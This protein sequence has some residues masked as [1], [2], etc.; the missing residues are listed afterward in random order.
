MRVSDVSINSAGLHFLLAVNTVAM[1]RKATNRKAPIPPPM[2]ASM[3]TTSVEE[4]IFAPAS[5]TAYVG[6][7]DGGG[8]GGGGDG[9]GEGGGGEGG[10]GDGGGDGGGEGG[11]GGGG[12]GDGG[13]EGGGGDGGGLWW[14]WMVV[15]G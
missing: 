9:G 4:S 7:G 15:D 10:G 8:E 1:I 14:R 13:G 2:R 3:E 12:D 11:G 5:V 6:G